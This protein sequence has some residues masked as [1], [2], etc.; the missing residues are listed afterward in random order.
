VF[1]DD[2]DR[3]LEVLDEAECLRLLAGAVIGRVAFTEAALPAIQP[4][5]YRLAGAEI[6][7]PSR[8]GSTVA[9]ASRRA[10]LAFSVDDVH[11][12]DRTGWSVTVVG[13]SRVI[14]AP[15]DVAEIE[16]TGDKLEG[17]ADDRCYIAISVELVHGRRLA[18]PLPSA[19]IVRPTPSGAYAPA[20][21]A[22][23]DHGAVGAEGS[24][25]RA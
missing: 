21:Q 17:R 15:A 13:P 16:R 19:R 4:V 5:F 14:S 8:S 22:A 2:G 24:P 20:R 18:P 1:A 12:P 23:A 7:I 25:G 9:T 6:L 10:V 3:V 11:V